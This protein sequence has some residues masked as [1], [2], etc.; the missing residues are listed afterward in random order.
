MYNDS[1]DNANNP[2]QC[3]GIST[4]LQKA[5]GIMAT[6][7]GVTALT[8][9]IIANNVLLMTFC[10]NSYF[11]W[12]IAELVLV[13]FLSLGI[14][15]M[16]TATATIAFY[17]YAIV[18]GITL[19]SV[20]LVYTNTSIVSTFLIT[21]LMFGSAAVYGKVTKR[22]LSSMGSFLFMALIGIII[23]SIVNLFMHSGTLSF[24]ISIVGI[25]VFVAFTAYDVKKLQDLSAFVDEG[26]SEGIRKIAII[27]ALQLYLD[28]I[29]IFI[30]LLSLFGKR[31][32]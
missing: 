19:F 20:F 18:N 15:N 7:L 11:V 27:G 9:F 31:R 5:F 25:I 30:K 29:N 12:I 17:A 13:F 23:A 8:S 22:D 10:Y 4:I 2:I 21:A 26:D 16:G 3:V 6:G 32:D 1:F 28:F 14:K 24:I